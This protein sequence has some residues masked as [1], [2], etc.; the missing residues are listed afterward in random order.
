VWVVHPATRT[1]TEYRTDV[2]R[3][4]TE[5]ATLQADDVIP[6]FRCRLKELF[7]PA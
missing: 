4:L 6:G 1:A 2:I 5:D 7:A 3:L